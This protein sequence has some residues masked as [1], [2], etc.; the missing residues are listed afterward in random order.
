VSFQGRFLAFAGFDWASEHHD[1][2]VL[3]G[4]GKLLLELTFADDAAGWRDLGQRLSQG[5]GL[6]PGRLGVAVETN[7]G[8]AVERLPAMGCV[9]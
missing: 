1:M 7:N 6:E 4:N 3:D 8:P 9:L 2:V 5:L